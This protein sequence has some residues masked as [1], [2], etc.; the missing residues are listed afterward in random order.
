MKGEVPRPSPRL[1]NLAFSCSASFY[2]VSARSNITARSGAAARLRHIA[3]SAKI[4]ELSATS[5]PPEQGRKPK[6]GIVFWVRNVHGQVL[7]ILKPLEDEAV[8]R[9]YLNPELPGLSV[10]FM[11]LAVVGRPPSAGT[12]WTAASGLLH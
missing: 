3:Q 2:V 11:H 7:A 1:N 10:T 4:A 12:A 5:A 6:A 8:K 9:I